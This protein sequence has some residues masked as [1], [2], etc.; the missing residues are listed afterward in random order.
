MYAFIHKT[1]GKPAFLYDHMPVR[2]ERVQSK[3]ARTLDGKEIDYGSERNCGSCGK[4]VIG[5]VLSTSRMVEWK[6]A[7]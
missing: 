4:P 7:Q 3:H 2:G 1:C 5:N 6:D